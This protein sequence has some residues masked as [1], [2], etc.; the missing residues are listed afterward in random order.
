MD[1]KIELC[2]SVN[3]KDDPFEKDECVF[4][5]HEHENWGDNKYCKECK[6]K[7]EI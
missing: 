3:L 6:V 4:C 2:N 1:K 5:I 7:G